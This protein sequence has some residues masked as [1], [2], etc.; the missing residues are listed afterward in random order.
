MLEPKNCHGKFRIFLQLGDTFDS[1]AFVVVVSLDFS[2]Y[3]RAG[4]F[5]RATVS[6][7]SQLY[8]KINILPI[9]VNRFSIA[10]DFNIKH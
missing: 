10:L 8:L 3:F 5:C 9:K 4:K 7:W 2:M 6:P 1:K